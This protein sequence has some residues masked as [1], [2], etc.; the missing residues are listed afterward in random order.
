MKIISVVEDDKYFAVE[1]EKVDF[2][3]AKKNI[4]KTFQGAVLH[5]MNSSAKL[6]FYRK[7]K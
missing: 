7:T 6:V 5:F 4:D 1:I 3:N 2:Q